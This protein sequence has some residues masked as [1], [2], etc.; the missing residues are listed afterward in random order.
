MAVRSPVRRASSPIR[1]DTVLVVDE[2]AAARERLSDVLGAAGYTT[3]E[4]TSGTEA[5]AATRKAQPD[6]IVL[7]VALPGVTGYDVCRTLRE[8]YGEEL[9]II[10]VSDERTQPL[11]RVAGLLMGADDYVVEPFAPA[12]L[13]ARVM[14]A[15][16]RVKSLRRVPR[17]GS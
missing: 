14:R 10:F 17:S 8:E 11:D 3:R 12:E 1:S 5:L 6:A 7:D 16:A 9:P 15:L 4:A 2:D 13:V